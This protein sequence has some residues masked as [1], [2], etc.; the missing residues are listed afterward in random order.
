[1]KEEVG[2]EIKDEKIEQ[3]EDE[4]KIKVE[5][6][7]E[8]KIKEEKHENPENII[9]SEINNNFDW[10]NPKKEESV[11]IE[12][13]SKDVEV[14]VEEA[15]AKV[16]EDN[17]EE[18]EEENI[19]SL[20]VNPI[21]MIE[22]N[23]P[24]QEYKGIYLQ[25]MNSKLLKIFIEIL[26]FLDSGDDIIKYFDKFNWSGDS[27]QLSLEEMYKLLWNIQYLQLPAVVTVSLL[28]KWYSH[29]LYLK[30]DSVKSIFC[31]K[32]E[33][34]PYKLQIAFYLTQNSE[35]SS[36]ENP[37]EN[38]E[39]YDL[40]KFLYKAYSNE[41]VREREERR[42]NS[43][44]LFDDQL[45]YLPLKFHLIQEE[46][47]EDKL[48]QLEVVRT[49]WMKLLKQLQNL[50]AQLEGIGPFNVVWSHFHESWTQDENPED[51]IKNWVLENDWKAKESKEEKK[52]CIIDNIEEICKKEDKNKEEEE[53]EKEDEQKETEK[54]LVTLQK[55]KLKTLT[56]HNIKITE[57]LEPVIIEFLNLPENKAIILSDK[58]KEKVDEIIKDPDEVEALPEKL[59]DKT[60]EKEE[61]SEFT[62]V[63]PLSLLETI[64]WSFLYD[65]IKYLFNFAPVCNIKVLELRGWI[66]MTKPCLLYILK[67]WKVIEE[68]DLS[69]LPNVDDE[70]VI[71]SS[72]SFKETLKIIQLRFWEGITM[73]GIIKFWENISGFSRV[74]K[75]YE[76]EGKD[77]SKLSYHFPT[78][79]K[80]ERINLADNK[81]LKNEIWKPIANFLFPKLGELNI[82]GNHYIDDKGFLDLWITRSNNFQRINYCGCYKVSDDSRLWL[83]N[84]FTKMIIY[85][86]VDDFGLPFYEF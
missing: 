62:F 25:T 59:D 8:N 20:L 64:N 32:T 57:R 26:K 80:L 9:E 48:E 29:P 58:I 52:E 12:D 49:N 69:F 35:D 60:D 5:I 33:L 11:N 63:T 44:F 17:K 55:S 37:L 66:T 4:N 56:E 51:F 3:K 86:K 77:T 38:N 15:N 70:I 40:W 42:E 7:I 43:Y 13:F 79:S 2:N 83:S 61:T 14:K 53:K 16:E 76:A 71:Q 50:F 24:Q 85:N 22:N 1:M 78:E 30:Y 28:I 67:T 36:V 10:E 47:E 73:A 39:N 41:R 68:L 23:Y 81:Q 6:S 27:D 65:S 84:Q 74:F 18:N 19:L 75:E 54:W 34:T 46:E 72:V 82:W 31:L 21:F 45:F